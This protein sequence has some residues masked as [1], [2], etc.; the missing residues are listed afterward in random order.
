M[1]L[2]AIN[3]IA[4]G[5]CELWDNPNTGGLTAVMCQGHVDTFCDTGAPW[6]LPGWMASDIRACAKGMKTRFKYGQPK[7]RIHA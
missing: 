4:K 1:K 5:N 2:G 6:E 7:V 3:L